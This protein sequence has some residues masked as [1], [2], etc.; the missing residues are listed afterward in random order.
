MDPISKFVQIARLQPSARMSSCH[1][2]TSPLFSLISTLNEQ[3]SR[4][5]SAGHLC[6]GGHG[7]SLVWVINYFELTCEISGSNDDRHDSP[8]DGSRKNLCNIC[9]YLHGTI[10]QKIYEIVLNV[11]K[12]HN[13]FIH[14]LFNYI[15]NYI[16]NL[17]R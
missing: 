12:H 14:N 10:H 3:I 6:F 2:P 16:Y 15:F 1:E 17:G 9:K 5:G 11:T 4:R 8:D 7:S 13:V